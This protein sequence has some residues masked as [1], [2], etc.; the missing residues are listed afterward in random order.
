[1]A[2][3]AAEVKRRG[4]GATRCSI[5]LELALG[6]PHAAIARKLR[7]S[8]PVIIALHRQALASGKGAV[9]VF[10]ERRPIR[11]GRPLTP[12]REARVQLAIKELWRGRPTGEAAR[13]TGLAMGTLRRIRTV[14]VGPRWRRPRPKARWLS[15]A[16]RGPVDVVGVLRDRG[17]CAVAVVLPKPA[18]PLDYFASPWWQFGE[19][20][21]YWQAA[22]GMSAARQVTRGDGSLYSPPRPMRTPPFVRRLLTR[23]AA[24]AGDIPARARGMAWWAPLRKFV[25][26]VASVT[27]A[28]FRLF[29]AFTAPDPGREPYSRFGCANRVVA[30]NRA[31][32]GVQLL[33]SPPGEWRRRTGELV[34]SHVGASMTIGAAGFDCA[35]RIAEALA[36]HP[37][38]TSAVFDP[39]V[40]GRVAVSP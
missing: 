19:W 12:D 33:Y 23:V 4:D 39:R 14:H 10:T 6:T 13:G 36:R 7:V 32:S 1:M 3:L 18:G 9:K 31:G 40:P 30:A 25:R 11:R 17:V 29:V 34:Q 22:W 27:P 28:S 37:A 26:Q 21:A 5:G 20:G 38:A 2:R 8:R 35:A 15:S 16:A 24:S